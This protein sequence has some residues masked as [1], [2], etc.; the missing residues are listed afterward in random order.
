MGIANSQLKATPAILPQPKCHLAS[1]L[2]FIIKPNK[3]MPT[4][5]W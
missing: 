1:N 5:M 3:H 2:P 4:R